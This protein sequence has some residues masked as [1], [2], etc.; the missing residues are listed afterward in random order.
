M[1]EQW[2]ALLPNMTTE[3]SKFI[4]FEKFKDM[5]TKK[6]THTQLTDEQILEDAAGI[7]K[8]MGKGR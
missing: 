4:S 5:N 2:I 6:N 8:T 1:W 7:L 3:G